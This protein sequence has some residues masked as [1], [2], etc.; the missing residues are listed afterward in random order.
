[1]RM[2]VGRA[3]HKDGV[4]FILVLKVEG[5][6]DLWV[7]RHSEICFKFQKRE[8]NVEERV[9]LGDGVKSHLGKLCFSGCMNHNE[10]G[11][12][13]KVAIILLAN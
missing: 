1:M 2:P 13:I 10:D 8:R 3:H 6:R 11:V 5:R 7:K 4:R 12:T 9:I